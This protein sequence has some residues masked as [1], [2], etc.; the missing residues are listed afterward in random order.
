[1]KPLHV[2]ANDG[3]DQEATN[4]SKEMFHICYM[5]DVLYGLQVQV[6]KY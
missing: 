3:H 5:H 1:M 2:L 4:T 6:F